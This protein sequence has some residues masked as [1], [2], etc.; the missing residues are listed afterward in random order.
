[1]KSF[2]AQELIDVVTVIAMPAV[3]GGEAAEPSQIPAVPAPP[4][5]VLPIPIFKNLKSYD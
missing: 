3:L 5:G 2:L 1:M 4:K